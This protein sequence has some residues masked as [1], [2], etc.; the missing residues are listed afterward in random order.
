MCNNIISCP[1]GI[2]YNFIQ[3]VIANIGG[4]YLIQVKKDFF[5]NFDSKILIFFI[6]IKHLRL[7]N[8]KSKRGKKE[9]NYLIMKII[10]GEK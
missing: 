1:N 8:N 6:I 7:N 4:P 9:S 10:K 5:K 2:K 3:Q